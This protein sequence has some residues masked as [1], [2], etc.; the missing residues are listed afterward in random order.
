MVKNECCSEVNR[1]E[2]ADVRAPHCSHAESEISPWMCTAA[3]SPHYLKVLQPER[4]STPLCQ[5]SIA[6]VMQN[7]F[8][9]AWKILQTS[10]WES[11]PVP[12]TL[13][14]AVIT[15]SPACWR[16]NL[17]YQG[18]HLL[19]ALGAHQPPRSFNFSGS[20]L[21]LRSPNK[22]LSDL[23]PQYT[24]DLLHQDTLSP[25]NCRSQAGL[26]CASLTPACLL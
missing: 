24:P 17:N 23:A 20:C 7:T 6:H 26:C 10:G 14:H 21:S 3:P 18:F 2:R 19:Q 13:I 16:S 25:E 22:C 15:S 1:N 4:R 5:T 9:F 12:K 8:F 11:D